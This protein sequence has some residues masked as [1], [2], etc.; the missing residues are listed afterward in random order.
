MTGMPGHLIGRH[1]GNARGH[2][3]YGMDGEF[4]LVVDAAAHSPDERA[5]AIVRAVSGSGRP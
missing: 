3:G 1:I 2:C 5:A 4:D